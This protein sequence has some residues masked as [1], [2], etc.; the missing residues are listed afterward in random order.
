MKLSGTKKLVWTYGK[1][2][3][4]SCNLKDLKGFFYGAVSS[5]FEQYKR[6]VLEQ[7]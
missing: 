3:Q 5:N 4:G 2:K 1:D 7:V 6:K